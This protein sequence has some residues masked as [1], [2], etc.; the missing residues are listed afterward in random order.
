MK[1]I[2]IHPPLD[3]PTAPYHST[4]YL[5]GHLAAR[6]FHDVAM[7]D[8]N[9]EYVNWLLQPATVA[10]MNE[11]AAARLDSLRRSNA[12]GF[13][14]Q[15]QYAG[16]LV[17]GQSNP[18]EIA[19]AAAELRTPESFLDFPRYVD[20]VG[21]IGGYLAM[22]GALSYPAELSGFAHTT[23]GRYSHSSMQD[24]LDPRLGDSVCMPFNRYF[25][26]SIANDPV[27]AAADLFG[28]SIVY[29]HQLY[30]ALQFSRLLKRLWPEK[31]LVLGGTAISHLYKYLKDKTR[32]KDLF[33]LCDAIVIGEGETA[34]C[35]IAASDGDLERGGYT[36]TITYRRDTDRLSLPAPAVRY[37][38]VPALGRPLYDHPWDL[39]L[40]PE[41]GINY[42]PTRGCYW[43]R[44][45]FCD[46][47]LNAGMPTSPWR[48]RPV[49]QVVEDLEHARRQCGVRYVYFAV[50]AMAPGYLERLADAICEARLDIRWSVSLRMEK[51]FSAARARRMARAGCVSVSFGME[52]GSQR[53][54]DL[55]DKG[56]NVRDMSATMQ[57]FAS[58]GVACQ[59]MAF[60]GFPT[61]TAGERQATYR[62]IR[63]TEPYWSAVG[64]GTFLL[65]GA[66]AIAGN[67]AKFGISLM[68]TEGADVARSVAYRVHGDTGRGPALT[69]DAGAPFPATQGRPWAGSIDSLHSVIYYDR[70]GPGFF[71]LNPHKPQA[72]ERSGG[73]GIETGGQLVEANFDL[74]AIAAN[75]KRFAEFVNG[76]RQIPA[77]PTH[78]AFAR[79]A[80]EV[81]PL[82]ADAGESYWLL[83]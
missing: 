30:H 42:A 12:L 23:R 79:W 3:D 75:R 31:R 40:S 54:L 33:T 37:E 53:I 72:G 8:V 2:L 41:R 80:R 55:I 67:P 27:F 77:E 65:T 4:A 26:E 50:D 60:T 25:E 22:L 48:E 43:N 21:T 56:T 62:L 44:C 46:Y 52:S 47:G 49:A 11:Q 63:E 16:L 39:Y 76:M 69:E 5:K 83:E 36:N 51:V 71:K 28:I 15:E 66:S 78:D 59:L 58:A 34:I 24:L 35:E 18:A 70:Y 7:R 45:T 74:A 29:D 10:A 20:N 14:A 13:E 57:N 64:M 9:I 32:I 61:E 1:L 82:P 19:R 17:A 73:R 6:G 81:P 38:D 68:A